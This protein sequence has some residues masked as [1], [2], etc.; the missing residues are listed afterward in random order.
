MS[1]IICLRRKGGAR[2]PRHIRGI[3]WASPLAAGLVGA[4]PLMGDYREIST[5]IGAG[6][7]TTGSPAFEAWSLGGLAFTTDASNDGASLPITSAQRVGSD[8]AIALWIKTTS[9]SNTIYAEI[10]GNSG[11]SIQQ[12][13]F[14]PTG[15]VKLNAGG[16]NKEINT[17][18]TIHDGEPHLVGFNKDPTAANGTAWVDGT[19]GT[20][21]TPDIQTPVYG[22]DVDIGLGARSGV[23]AAL[24]SWGHLL[25][26]SR[27]LSSAEWAALY[28]SRHRFDI[29]DQG[30]R[31]F[32]FP[33]SATALDLRFIRSR[34]HAYRL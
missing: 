8:F 7:A 5:G 34:R 26:W 9:L 15:S 25:L 24:G 4:W 20:S 17:S 30:R 31:F 21:G 12:S 23:A 3:N 16:T 28:G 33:A 1:E 19:E 11:W 14:G 10:N 2:P 27:Q 13:N 6:R 18:A 32:S 22:A 29:Y